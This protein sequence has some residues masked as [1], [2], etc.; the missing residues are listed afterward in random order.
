[1]FQVK[2]SPFFCTSAGGRFDI[3]IIIMTSN[4]NH[5]G[6]TVAILKLRWTIE[7]WAGRPECMTRNMLTNNSS[8]DPRPPHRKEQPGSLHTARVLMHMRTIPQN[9]GNPVT[10][11]N[12]Q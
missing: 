3:I 2:D 10:S 12:Y 5:L 1:M 7:Q 8:L 9:L 6:C 11:V 4:P